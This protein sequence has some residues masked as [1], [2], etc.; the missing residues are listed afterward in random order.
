MKIRI[1]KISALLLASIAFASLADAQLDSWI[2]EA[3]I[4]NPEIRAASNR[5]AVARANVGTMGALPDPMAGADVERA[6]TSLRSFNDIEYMIQQDVPWFGKRDLATKG[7][8]AEARMAEMEFRMKSLET[9]S[10]VKISAYDLWQAQQEIGI[11]LR[12]LSL[13]DKIEKAASVRYE[14]GKASQADVIKAGVETTKLVENQMELSRNRETASAELARLLGREQGA[15]FGEIQPLPEP[16]IIIDTAAVRE[17][18]AAMHP[19]L[20]G[21]R[22]G[23]I[24]AAQS[25]L[26]LAKRSYRPDFQF[27]VEARQFN[28][29]AGIQEYDTAVFLNLPW[30][31]KRK[32]DNTVAMAKATLDARKDDYEAMRQKQLANAQKLSVGIATLEHHH[33]LYRERLIPQQRA[34]VEATRASYESGAASLLEVFDAQRMLLDLEMTDAHHIADTWRQIAELEVLTGGEIPQIA[35][36]KPK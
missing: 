23:A 36:E 18:V 24:A 3:L 12:A 28:G 2:T 16:R 6:N 13:L 15:S 19:S 10:A 30:F 9:A 8:A 33:E 34:A 17:R 11:N 26:D 25:Q 20:I 35:A 31:N 5:W 4:K 27:R 14:N 22:E 1:A 21:A 32:N 7:A 29:Q